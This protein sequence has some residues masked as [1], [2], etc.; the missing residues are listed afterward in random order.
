MVGIIKNVT[1]V[2][3][4]EKI[5]KLTQHHLGIKALLAVAKN[6]NESEIK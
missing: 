5:I 2:N 1:R 4:V 6:K 3:C